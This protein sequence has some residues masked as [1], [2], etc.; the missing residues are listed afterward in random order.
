MTIDIEIKTS[1]DYDIYSGR[2]IIVFIQYEPFESVFY[3]SYKVQLIF[4]MEFSRY[5]CGVVPNSA[6]NVLQKFAA[7]E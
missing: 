7:V 6:L 3:W 4:G 1:R 2:M 5:I